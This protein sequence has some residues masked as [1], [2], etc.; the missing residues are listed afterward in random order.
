MATPSR[1]MQFV[2]SPTGPKT[3]HFWGPVANW[4]FVLAGLA[5]TRKEESMISGPMTGA[6]TVYSGL[7]MRFAWQVQPRNYILLACHAAN[8]T[9]QSYNFQRWY[10]WSQLE[11]QQE[12][13][14]A[15]L[16]K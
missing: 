11:E 12:A 9:V 8:G 16:N 3:T 7:F 15:E 10:R 4:G 13:A 5:D 14:K 1:L 6:L 2:N